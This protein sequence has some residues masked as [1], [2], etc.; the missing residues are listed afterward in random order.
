MDT[1][2]ARVHEWGV[3]R[4]WAHSAALLLRVPASLL[5][6]TARGVVPFGLLYK[7]YSA[8]VN[9][10]PDVSTTL[11]VETVAVACPSCKAPKLPLQYALHTPAIT[12]YSCPARPSC[13]LSGLA[14]WGSDD[15]SLAGALAA[16]HREVLR[17]SPEA[18]AMVGIA[19]TKLVR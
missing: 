19:H 16:A 10:L 8:L 18:N 9:L 15:D 1:C 2:Y 7:F 4:P 12:C 14:V 3:Q 5:Q 6:M 11:K 17:H 13:D